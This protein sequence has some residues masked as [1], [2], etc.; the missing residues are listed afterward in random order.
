MNAQHEMTNGEIVTKGGVGTGASIGAW[1]LS[2]IQQINGSLQTASL[3]LGLIIGAVS[4]WKLITKKKKS[5]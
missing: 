1:Y 5:K 2:H 4:L 3:I